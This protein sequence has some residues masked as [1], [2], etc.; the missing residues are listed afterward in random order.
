MLSSLLCRGRGDTQGVECSQSV[1]PFSAWIYTVPIGQWMEWFSV[2]KHVI[3]FQHQDAAIIL[4]LLKAV[5]FRHLEL[6]LKCLKAQFKRA[7]C[8]CPQEETEPISVIK[9]T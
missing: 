7:L 9:K 2:F 4:L 1:Q 5:R 6:K 3:V 8:C